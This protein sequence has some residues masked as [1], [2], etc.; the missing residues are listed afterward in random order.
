MQA[1]CGICL[2]VSFAAAVRGRGRCR[3]KTSAST[4]RCRWDPP[5]FAILS[6]GVQ[7]G[8]AV[9]LVPFALL[10]QKTSAPQPQQVWA[11]DRGLRPRAPHAN[12]LGHSPVALSLMLPAGAGVDP[13]T[14]AFRWAHKA[15]AILA[16]SRGKQSLQ[17]NPG[18]HNLPLANFNRPRGPN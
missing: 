10:V 3:I 12:P 1:P 11:Q 6:C 5:S 17:A 14:E 9:A 7:G 18:Q 15:V 2:V 13:L 16:E 4:C 8:A